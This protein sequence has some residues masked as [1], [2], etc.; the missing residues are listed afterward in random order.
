[1]GDLSGA[2]V[3]Y[4]TVHFKSDG[5]ATADGTT[6]CT[7]CTIGGRTG[8]FTTNYHARLS[9]DGHLEGSLSVLSA[10][11]GLVGLHAVDQF[12]GDFASGTG[13]YSYSYTFEP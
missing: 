8:D 6:V 5:S 1:M 13:T 4:A 9:A 2:S 7:G 3:V 11:G 10:T 12:E